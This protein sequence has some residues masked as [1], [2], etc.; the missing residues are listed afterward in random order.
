MKLFEVSSG[1]IGKCE[2]LDTEG[3]G[4]DDT[5]MECEVQGSGKMDITE[6]ESGTT[7]SE[8]LAGNND[9]DDSNDFEFTD[10]KTVV[11]SSHRK[12]TSYCVVH[13]VSMLIAFDCLNY[14]RSVCI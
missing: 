10:V 14:L 13:L 4:E 1:N 12:S 5:E 8:S 11:V 7:T 2:K 9:H 3:S 6:S